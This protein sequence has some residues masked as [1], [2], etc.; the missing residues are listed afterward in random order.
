MTPA[1]AGHSGPARLSVAISLFNYADYI[2]TALASV[3]QQTMA[4][5]IELIVVDDAST[6]H[7]LQ[8][9][10]RF[11][12]ENAALVGRLAAFHLERHPQ[13]R[14]LAEARNSAFA[15]A[16]TP[17]VLVLDADNRLLPEACACLLEALEQAPSSVGATYPLLVVEGH[18]SQAIANELPWNPQRLRQGNTLDALAL[19]RRSAWQQV[20]GFVHTPGGWEDYDFWCRFVEAGLSALQV[21]QL[22]AVYHHHG[23]SMKNS[24]TAARQQELRQLLQRRHPWLELTP[25]AAS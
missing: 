24:E 6:D 1:P 20:G 10:E 18:S 23:D 14:G 22:L 12:Q 8:T 4:E 17:Q 21:P 5:A 16:S 13:N 25:A 19:V 7:S 15:L 3:C 9:V 2:S 11:Q